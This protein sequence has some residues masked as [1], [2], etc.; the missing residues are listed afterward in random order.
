MNKYVSA[1][2]EKFSQESTW[3]GIVALLTAFGVTLE[4]DKANAI[5][6]AGL[7]VIGT[8]NFAKDK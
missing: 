8:I 1:F 5:I 6:A 4:P 2:I 3:R 7:F